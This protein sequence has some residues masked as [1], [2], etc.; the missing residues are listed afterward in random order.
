MIEL[1]PGHKYG[2]TISSPVMPAA[3]T[4][5]Y[6]DAYRNLIDEH[7]LGAIV[8]NPLSLRPRKAAKGQRL[9][10]RGEHFIVHT[11]L[12]NAG[13]R[14]IIRQQRRQWERASIPIIA[15]LIATNPADTAKAAAQL[16]TARGVRGIELGLV[17]NVE[18]EEALQLLSAAQSGGGMPVIVRVPFSRV[19]TLIPIL[20][21]SGADALTLTAPPR[22]VTA[23]P[24]EEG[25]N[26]TRFMRGRL[27]GPALFPLLLNTLSQWAT[28]GA[29]QPHIPI[30]AC[31][32]I[33]SP[34]DAL[35]CLS[36]GAAAVQIDAILWRDPTLLTHIAEGLKELVS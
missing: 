12:P 19:D 3:G 17:E 14:R 5:G 16:S 32:G 34:E 2:L 6:G 26:V 28:P 25:A 8:T 27:Y 9:A 33:A 29:F 15:H 18:E 20:A 30:I 10:K 11:G 13:V 1:A 7:V 24:N 36:L 31:G 22:A 23:L 35:A 21:E 4:F